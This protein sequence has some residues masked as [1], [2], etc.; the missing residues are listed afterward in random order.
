MKS[1]SL[2]GHSAELIRIM[3]KSPLAPD[4]VAK[5]F[6]REKKY[7]GSRERKAISE[8][9]FSFL[10]LRYMAEACSPQ[11]RTSSEQEPLEKEFL[12]AASSVVLAGILPNLREYSVQ[13]LDSIKSASGS[14]AAGLRQIVDEAIADRFPSTGEAVLFSESVI[15]NFESLDATTNQLF[16]N[17][18]DGNT[19]SEQE[20]STLASRFSAGTFFVEHLLANGQTLGS[21]KKITEELFLPAKLCLRANTALISRESL[22]ARLQ[23]AGHCGKLSTLSPSGL[24]I[25]GRPRLDESDEFRAGMFDIQDIGSQ[26]ISYALSPTPNSDVLDACAGAGG[27]SLHLATIAGGKAR[28]V[29]TDI[30]YNRLKEIQNRAYRMGIQNIKPR[31]I[32]ANDLNAKPNR[33]L[34]AELQR[35][36]DF[37]LVDAPCSGTGTTRRNP[38]PKYRITKKFIEKINSSQLSILEQYARFVREG[39]ALVYSTCSIM[40]AENDNVCRRFLEANPDFEPEPL[41]PVFAE[42]GIDILAATDERASLTLYPASDSSDGF[43]MARFRRKD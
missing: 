40:P 31:I 22:L 9:S 23:A 11:Y 17:R 30:E 4:A 13:L 15:S 39:G 34:L 25:N 28:I 43:F 12:A 19:F 42:Q 2:L 41:A 10:R 20:L 33:E 5:Q 36:F 16:A 1:S 32:K 27:K 38:L 14:S 6:L 8:I 18:P 29:A 7:I 37:V 21:V 24:I 3:V 35:G 26:L